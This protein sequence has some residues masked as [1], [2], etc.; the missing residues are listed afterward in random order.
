[1]TLTPDDIDRNGSGEFN[2]AGAGV[3]ISRWEDALSEGRPLDPGRWYSVTTDREVVGLIDCSGDEYYA[4]TPQAVR[5][6][7]GR[8]VSSLWEGAKWLVHE[9]WPQPEAE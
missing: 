8:P 6:G 7:L 4:F 3:F 9:R 5:D 2:V 1:M